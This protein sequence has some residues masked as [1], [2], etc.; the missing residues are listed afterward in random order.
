M[1]PPPPHR[2]LADFG[3]AGPVV[4]DGGRSNALEDRDMSDCRTRDDQ[5]ALEAEFDQ[6]P[7]STFIRQAALGGQAR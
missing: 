2:Q 3:Q 1:D 7:L 4:L 6:L 5:A